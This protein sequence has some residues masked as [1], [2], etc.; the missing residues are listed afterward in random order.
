MDYSRCSFCR[1]GAQKFNYEGENNKD[2]IVSFMRN[3]SQ[4]VEKPKEAEWSDTQS[5]V[6]H[7][8]SETFDE[9]LK[10]QS[11]VLVMF[12]APW[13]GHCKRMKPEYEKAAAKL[14]DLK[15]NGKLAAVDAQKHSALG[16]RFNVRGYPSVKYFKNGELAFDV[17]LREEGA[18]VDF[19]KDPKEPPPP[20][21]P[22]KAWSDEPSDVLHLND[23]NFKPIL[24]KT[25]HA[26]VIFYAPCKYIHLGLGPDWA[27]NS[28]KLDC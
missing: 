2:G 26:L 15:L 27:L 16:S 22:E 25:K 20:P 8:T 3:P 19:M 24:K 28:S 11:S 5:E 10:T 23:D 21:P 9:Y 14:A 1:N 7:L 4:P 17:S 13:C 6:A 12:Y 18:I